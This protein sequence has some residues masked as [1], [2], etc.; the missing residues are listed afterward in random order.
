MAWNEK[1]ETRGDVEKRQEFWPHFWSLKTI[2]ILTSIEYVMVISRLQSASD[3]N[4]ASNSFLRPAL[5][6]KKNFG[7]ER[8]KQNIQEGY[9]IFNSVTKVL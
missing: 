8:E 6:T 7:E 2:F 4:P 1:R 3:R 5:S 9:F